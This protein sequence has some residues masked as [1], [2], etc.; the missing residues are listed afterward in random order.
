M[1]SDDGT[2]MGFNGCGHQNI[3]LDLGFKEGG[4]G[5]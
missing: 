1:I 3:R 2:V 5:P 4:D